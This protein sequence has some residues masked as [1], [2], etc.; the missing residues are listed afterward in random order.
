MQTP[1]P[2]LPAAVRDETVSHLTAAIEA[3]LNQ[4][5]SLPEVA[6]LRRAR[7]SMDRIIQR[8]DPFPMMPPTELVD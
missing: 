3:L 4:D 5:G 6:V 2:A 8:Y 7:R 1:H